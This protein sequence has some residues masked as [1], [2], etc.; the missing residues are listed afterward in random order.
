MTVASY[1][2]T[3]KAYCLG[4]EKEDSD[5]SDSHSLL[6]GLTALPTQD[7]DMTVA[8][9]LETTKAYCLGNEKEDSDSSDSQSLSVGLTALPTQD[10]DMTV[11]SYLETMKAYCLGN[12]KEDSDSSDS[13]SLLVGLT[14]LPTQDDDT[15]TTFHLE[16]TKTYCLGN[17]EEDSDSSDS[18]SLLVGLTALPTQDDDMAA[19]LESDNEREEGRGFCFADEC[20]PIQACANGASD[21]ENC[22]DYDDEGDSNDDGENH[23]DRHSFSSNLHKLDYDLKVTQRYVVSTGDDYEDDDCGDGDD[24]DEDDGGGHEDGYCNSEGERGSLGNQVK[25]RGYEL[26]DFQATKE[27]SVAGSSND[28]DVDN[29]DDYDERQQEY[30]G[31]VEEHSHET[32]GMMN[33]K[34]ALQYTTPQGLE[35]T[36]G[37]EADEP[38]ENDISVSLGSGSRDRLHARSDKEPSDAD[39]QAHELVRKLVSLILML[40]LNC[41][42]CVSGYFSRVAS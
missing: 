16:K 37:C 8:S 30:I 13:Q 27:Y 31:T 23:E 7:D 5:S 19:T 17:E 38:D 11:A 18:Q 1:L 39:V 14:V 9:Y 36:K 12:E 4:N 20:P 22:Y 26:T 35:E 25:K 21:D 15:I 40:M 24:E 34:D 10:D 6:V 33:G 29:G 42:L 3:T 32:F 2:E 41:V 28:D